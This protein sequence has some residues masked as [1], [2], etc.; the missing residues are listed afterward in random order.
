LTGWDW[1]ASVLFE[2]ILNNPEEQLTVFT[3]V[4]IL[5]AE[6]HEFRDQDYGN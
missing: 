5:P 6:T 2:P 1:F 3:Q 4:L